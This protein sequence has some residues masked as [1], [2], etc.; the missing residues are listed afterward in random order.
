VKT[1]TI[2]TVVDFLQVPSDRR[3]DC[4]REFAAW[5]DG[6]DLVKAL[7]DGAGTLDHF[8]WI[9][10]GRHL[11]DLQILSTTGDEPPFRVTGGMRK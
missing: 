9:D 8:E 6:A 1:Y 2:R 4:L 11:F 7:L 3:D 5:L 10:D